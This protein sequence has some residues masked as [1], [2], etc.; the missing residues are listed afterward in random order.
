MNIVTAMDA[1]CDY[2]RGKLDADKHGLQFKSTTTPTDYETKVPDVFGF[3]MPQTKLVDRYPASCPCVCV[4]LNGR[5]ENKYTLC[6]NL[7]VSSSSL[8]DGEMANPVDFNRYEFDDSTGYDTQNDENL[9][10]ESIH[11]T[12]KIY[13]YIVTYQAAVSDVVVEYETPDLPNHPYA[14][15]RVTFAITVN[16]DNIGRNAFNELY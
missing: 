2:L 13:E 8:S 15:S 4:T 7:C 1:F 5:N 12:D 3:T 10:V 11:F 6:A 9:L 14:V 16:Q